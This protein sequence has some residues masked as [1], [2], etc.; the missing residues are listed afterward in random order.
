M[1]SPSDMTRRIQRQCGGGQQRY[2]VYG[3]GSHSVIRSALYAFCVPYRKA[4]PVYSGV[5]RSWQTVSV[6]ADV[7]QEAMQ[8]RMY[9]VSL[10]TR[11]RRLYDRERL[12]RASRHDMIAEWL[13][14]RR[15][16][17]QFTWGQGRD[18]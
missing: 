6:I 5:K 15:Q 4:R 8:E 13:A 2:G 17:R 11:K 18:E 12:D 14:E 1:I 10:D 9:Q 7:V 3:G 16:F